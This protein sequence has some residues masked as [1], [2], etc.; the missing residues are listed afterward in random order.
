V[1]TLLDSP[2]AAPLLEG[3]PLT[4]G[5]EVLAHLSR[6]PLLDVYD[7]WSEERDC[8]CVAKLLR[9]D[10]AAE[11]R[12][13]RRLVN[14][15]RLLE[16]LTHPHIVRAYETLEEP[17]PIVILETLTGATLWHLIASRNRRLPLAD[18]LYLGLHLCSAVRYLHLSG[19]LHRDLK[20]TNIVS[21]HGRAK[22]L[23]L[24]LARPPGPA[25]PGPGTPSYMAPEQARGGELGAAVD[26]W[27]IGAVLYAAA[28]GRAPFDAGGGA[29]R[30]PQL[31]RVADPVSAQRRVPAAFARAVAGCLEPA[32]ADRPAVG[33]LAPELDKLLD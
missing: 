31:D 19:V 10:R 25:R 17:Q 9:P 7:V 4:A 3:A 26:V 2:A 22:L 8:R 16:R 11:E 15:G 18:L 12:A 27:G 1:T 23:D 6:G 14:E 20:P 29:G 28:V 33:E 13:R 5:Y 24:S 32:P 30:Y 21:D